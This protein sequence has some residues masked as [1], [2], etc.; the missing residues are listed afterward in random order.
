MGKKFTNLPD[1]PFVAI[2]WAD[3]WVDGTEAIALTDVALKHKASMHTTIG[4]LLYKTPDGI[5]VANEYCQEDET[6]RGRTYIPSGMLVSILNMKL[7][8]LPDHQ[9]KTAKLVASVPG[10]GPVKSEE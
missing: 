8:K 6:F 7:S 10:S 9:K 3:A 5:S 1:L 4:W 2:T